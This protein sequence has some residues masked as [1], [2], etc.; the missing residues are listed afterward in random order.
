MDGSFTG[1]D[2]KGGM[3]GVLWDHHGRWIIIF[4]K[5]KYCTSSNIAKLLA[6]KT[7]LDIIITLGVETLEINF[8]SQLLIH[9]ILNK[10]NPTNLAL[11]IN[12]CRWRLSQLA[13]YK[14]TH[15]WREMNT[16]ADALAKEENKASATFTT[17]I[18]SALYHSCFS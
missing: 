18:T 6:L 15:C 2:Q 14:I 12:D 1:H 8:D 17:F 10:D 11:I 4:M 3:G 16:I 7:G 9:Y 13:E 5:G